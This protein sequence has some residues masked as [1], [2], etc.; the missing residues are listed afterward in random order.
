MY[1]SQHILNRLRDR[2][3]QVA[4]LQEVPVWESKEF[5]KLS[6]DYA[7]ISSDISECAIIL[8][9]S[10]E[11]SRRRVEAG[12]RFMLVQLNS[13]VIASL[14]LPCDDDRAAKL[15][16]EEFEEILHNINN[17]LVQWMTDADGAPPPWMLSFWELMQISG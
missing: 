2:R 3:V 1:E 16:D 11:P 4:C 17:I 8:S 10:L 7:L 6:K 5:S 9:K 14:H 12:A 13:L 15:V